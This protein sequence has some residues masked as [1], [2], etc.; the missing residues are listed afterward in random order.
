M[1][2][3]SRDAIAQLQMRAAFLEFDLYCEVHPH[4]PAA[5]RRPALLKRRSHWLVLLGPNEQTGIAGVGS[6]P[7][8][9]A[10]AFELQ[11]LNMLR[12]PEDRLT[13]DT[14]SA[15]WLSPSS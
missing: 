2:N 13:S 15:T 1:N 5:V 6:T 14:S 8:E 7:S 9:A 3:V 4:G 11:Y 12:P 10:R